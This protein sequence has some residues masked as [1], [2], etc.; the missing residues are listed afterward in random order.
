[1]VDSPTTVFGFGVFRSLF[2]TVSCLFSHRTNPKMHLHASWGV[3]H[4]L[5][6]GLAF[7]CRYGEGFAAVPT[8]SSRSQ[9]TV[10][11]SSASPLPPPG[12]VH[13]WLLVYVLSSHRTLGCTELG[14]SVVVVWNLLVRCSPVHHVV[15][16]VGLG[17]NLTSCSKPTVLVRAR[18]DWRIDTSTTSRQPAS[19]WTIVDTLGWV[20]NS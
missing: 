6:L 14:A 19:P 2:A 10:L 9:R 13:R 12:A 4:A 16:Q 20:R 8:A 5:A 7:H 1:M 18:T 11:S 17:L 3:H 15:R